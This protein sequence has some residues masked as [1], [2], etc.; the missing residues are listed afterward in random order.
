MFW[1]FV[2]DVL[3]K[4]SSSSYVVLWVSSCKEFA[5]GEQ[6]DQ[7]LVLTGGWLYVHGDTNELL[8]VI[9][10]PWGEENWQHYTVFVKFSQQFN[11][12]SFFTCFFLPPWNTRGW[13]ASF[14]EK[15]L[16]YWLYFTANIQKEKTKYASA[17]KS[18]CSLCPSIQTLQIER[19]FSYS[20]WR[21][22]TISGVKLF[23]QRLFSQN[24]GLM[25]FSYCTS[26]GAMGVVV[27]S[28]G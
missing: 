5:L 18:S 26:P 25:R 14:Q 19:E 21:N 12:M 3:L 2:A 7:T 13:R 1:H 4:V 28:K 11:C 24:T 6:S 27:A 8:S 22:K 10:W 9:M 23:T 16:Q 17:H 20:S 15:L